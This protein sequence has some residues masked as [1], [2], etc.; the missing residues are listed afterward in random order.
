MARDLKAAPAANEVLDYRS[1]L[2]TVDEVCDY[3]GLSRDFVYDQVRDGALRCS[4]IA[5]QLRFRFA[6]VDAFVDQHLIPSHVSDY[7]GYERGRGH[8]R[9]ARR[10]VGAS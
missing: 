8:P 7:P 9:S 5:R 6:D 1:R 4:R 10:R 2:M 3:L